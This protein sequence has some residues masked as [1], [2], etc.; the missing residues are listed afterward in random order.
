MGGVDE[1]LSGDQGGEKERS[2]W[3]GGRGEVGGLHSLR[4]ERLLD[5]LCIWEGH[6]NWHN[7]AFGQVCLRLGHVCARVRPQHVCVWET[8]ERRGRKQR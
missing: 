8:E 3:G 2:R 5:A 4:A 6:S 1:Q 7:E